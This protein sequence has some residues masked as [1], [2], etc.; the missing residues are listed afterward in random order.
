VPVA[1]DRQAQVVLSREADGRDDVGG[2][3]RGDSVNAWCGS[4]GAG[5]RRKDDS[6]FFHSRH[7]DDV[8]HLSGHSS[9]ELD[10]LLDCLA[11]SMGTGDDLLLWQEYQRILLHESPVTVLFYP[12]SLVGVADHLEGFVTRAVTG[13]QGCGLTAAA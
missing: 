6:F 11:L 1:F 10:R 3:L 2:P 13:R 9:A 4:P 8:G 5:E 12:L 7:R